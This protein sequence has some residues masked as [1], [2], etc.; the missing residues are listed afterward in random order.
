MYKL[1]L[2]RH[3]QSEWN[4]E[5]KFTGW[6]DSEL[7]EKGLE[8]AKHAGRLLKEK[9]FNFDMAYTSVLKR[10]IKTLWT[11]QEEMNLLWI[12]VE[13]SWRLNERHYGD[14]QGLNKKET[15]KKYGEDQVHTWRR[16]YD[17][18][19]PMMDKNDERHPSNQAQYQDVQ[20][21]FIPS[22]ESL[23]MTLERVLP[24]WNEN[25]VPNVQDAM[26]ILIV[27]HGNSIRSL[28]KHLANISDNEITKVEIP[29]ASPLVFELDEDLKAIK[30]YYLDDPDKVKR[31]QEAVAQQSKV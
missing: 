9:G 26:D 19:P 11:I 12:P 23:K 30:Q 27:A 22:G 2:V 1:V 15:A 21:R 6:Y 18:P 29:T 13:R 25:I 5:N 7:S 3:G 28:I 24:Y 16:S 17:T 14:L 4:K 8:E 20:N 31:E 10:A